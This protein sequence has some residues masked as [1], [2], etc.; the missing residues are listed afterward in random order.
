MEQFRLP[1]IPMPELTLPQAIQDVLKEAEQKL[2]HR[3]KLLQLFK[4]CFPNTL[5]TTT[6][7]MDDGTTFVITGDIPAMWLRDSVEQVMHY[8]PFAKHDKDLQRI[9]SGLIKRH[10]SL[11]S[12]RPLCECVQ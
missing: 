10:I 5:E 8:V 4:N 7:L 3:P 12:N 9:L 6:K 2:A 1:K 11:Y